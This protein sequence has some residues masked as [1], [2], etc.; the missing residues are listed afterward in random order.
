MRRQHAGQRK[1][2]G[3]RFIPPNSVSPDGGPWADWQTGAISQESSDSRTTELGSNSKKPASW[4]G[5]DWV[6][7]L[8]HGCFW[9]RL[10][11]QTQPI[12]PQPTPGRKAEA[13]AQ[14][15]AQAAVQQARADTQRERLGAAAD[16]VRPRAPRSSSSSARPKR[17]PPT[18]PIPLLSPFAS[19]TTPV[20]E[21]EAEERRAGGQRNSLL[22]SR[23]LC[24]IEP[25]LLPANR[26]VGWREERPAV[27][28]CA[29]SLLAA[30]GSRPAISAQRCDTPLLH[31]IPPHLT[32][33]Q[34]AGYECTASAIA[35]PSSIISP[36]RPADPYSDRPSPSRLALLPTDKASTNPNFRPKQLTALPDLTSVAWAFVYGSTSGKEQRRRLLLSI[37]LIE[38]SRSDECFPR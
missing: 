29:A 38:Q 3:R 14:A 8:A 5:G 4:A 35:C 36:S 28:L 31:T 37:P 18:P 15:H 22:A 32:S 9:Q 19:S 16:A 25:V 17:K 6:R 33:K 34:A 7:G 27:P 30:R 2:A 10:R 26:T 21:P 23:C 1:T 13:A 11:A 24:A 20:G 12:R